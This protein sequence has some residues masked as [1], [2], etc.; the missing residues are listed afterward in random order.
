MTTAMNARAWFTR[1]TLI[2]TF[3]ASLLAACGGG[4]GGTSVVGGGGGMCGG[5]GQPACVGG[6]YTATGPVGLV[7]GK[8]VIVVST[9]GGIH[10]GQPSD[11][12]TPYL[13]TF[14]GF[15]GL[16]DVDFVFA[17]GLGMGPDAEAKGLAEARAQMVL[18]RARRE[19]I[20][21]VQVRGGLEYNHELL[22]SA[23]FAKGWEGIAEAAV[24]IPLFNRNQGNVTAARADIDRAMQE[25]RRI[26]LT[27]RERAAFVHLT[28]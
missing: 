27:L 19:A 22:G 21:D 3:C 23:P 8:K 11:G 7:I 18:Q 25:K 6:A 9:R 4:G 14:L 12:V 26:E 1:S 16:S 28:V 20:P 15:L 10:R 13:R 17:E 5:Y 24:Q 2:S